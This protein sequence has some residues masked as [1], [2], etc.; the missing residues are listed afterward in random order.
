MKKAIVAGL[1]LT[2][3]YLTAGEYVKMENPGF[4]AIENGVAK[5]WS[6]AGPAWRAERGA[7]LNGSGALV[8][9][10]AVAQHAPRPSQAVQ[11][12]PGRKY[13]ISARVIADGLKVDRPNSSAQGMTVMLSWFDAKGKWLGEAVATKAAKGK[14]D[15]WTV[16]SVITPDMPAAATRFVVE[17]YVCGYGVGKGRIDN[18]VVETVDMNPVEVV[19][20]SAYR[21]ESTGG[22]VRFAATVNWSD[23][24]PEKEQ[25]AYFVYTGADGKRVKVEAAKV[26][27]GVTAEIDTGLFAYGT[28]DVLCVIRAGGK[29]FGT[30]KV[31]FAHLKELPYRRCRID[32]KQR[33]IVDGKPFFPLGMYTG[34]MDEKKI[35][36]YARSPFNCIGPY[37]TWS[38]E[39]LDLLHSHGLKVIYSLCHAPSREA[40]YVPN[41]CRNVK[42]FA[43][44]HPAVI[45][46]YI[47]DEPTL[48]MLSDIVAWRRRIE[49]MDGG[50]HPIWGVLCV[51]N[52]TRHVIDAFDVLGIDPYPVPGSVARV[53]HASR[54][55]VE[56]MFGTKAMWNVPQAFGWGWLGRR[57]T[58]GQRA[59]NK[60]EIANMTWQMIAGGANGIVYYSYS[61]L[62]DTYEEIDD[63]A[64]IYWMKICAAAAEVKACERIL[65]AGGDAPAVTP[66]S[67][68]LV[69][70]SWRDE[71]GRTYVLAVNITD[72]PLKADVKLGESFSKIEMPD[73]G[74][75]PTLDG[76]RLSYD[77]PALGYVMLRLAK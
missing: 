13:K 7:G 38:K 54:T 27:C 21:N 23:N 63:H 52:D 72:R 24:F 76:G 34:S 3:G 17:P 42:T 45:G 26:P 28:N 55:S 62:K 29:T 59:P 32:A 33:L 57:E 30:G 16:A 20:S 39:R 68:D 11:L 60:V 74:P 58:K 66:S 2:A 53:T 14:T 5:G 15:E 6:K 71:A 4:D 41:L 1:C 67:P 56:G 31:A 10:S 19:T 12:K 70:R 64:A 8:Y 61:Q 9:D 36:H 44:D 50:Q 73:F 25:K 40:S 69:C 46:W 77:L 37:C 43:A 35:A 48:G 47:C 18:V 49:E 22:K 65:L 51:F 75:A